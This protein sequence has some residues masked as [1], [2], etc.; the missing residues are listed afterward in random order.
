MPKHIN[1][2]TERHPSVPCYSP[3]LFCTVTLVVTKRH[4][5]SQVAPGYSQVALQAGWGVWWG[6]QGVG[7]LSAA[8]RLGATEGLSRHSLR[9][10]R[11]CTIPFKDPFRQIFSMLGIQETGKLF[12]I[13]CFNSSISFDIDGAPSVRVSEDK[14]QPLICLRVVSN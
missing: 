1:K 3:P 9:R 14:R 2:S 8:R 10:R 4:V 11:R 13:S 5:G 6:V 7:W 12:V